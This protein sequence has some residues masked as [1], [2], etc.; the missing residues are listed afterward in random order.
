MTT[1]RVCWLKFS[2]ELRISRV[3]RALRARFRYF[4]HKR[5]ANNLGG[6]FAQYDNPEE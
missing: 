6:P 5:T 1:S 4:A 3:A 2:S